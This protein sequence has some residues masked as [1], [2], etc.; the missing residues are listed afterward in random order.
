MVPGT[1]DTDR[2]H[3]HADNRDQRPQ[4]PLR[5][6]RRGRAGRLPQRGHDD[7]PVLGAPDLSLPAALPLSAARLSRPAAERQAGPALD[8]R[9]SRRRSAGSARSPRD[10]ALPSGRHLLRWRGG[11][12]LRLHLAG[13]GQEP[14]GDLV[15]QRGGTRAGSRGGQLA[16]DGP[17]GAGVALPGRS[18]VQLLPPR[19][20]S[21]RTTHRSSNRAKNGY[22]P[23]RPSSSPPSPGWSTPSARPTSPPSSSASSARPSS[24]WASRTPSSRPST[25]G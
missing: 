10:R 6:A 23:A 11:H 7:H 18:A 19:A 5:A 2:S 4:H 14:V 24:W 12:G 16:H 25:A 1:D 20:G 13:P 17:R 3:Q 8:A 9:R 22:A 15:G 21:S